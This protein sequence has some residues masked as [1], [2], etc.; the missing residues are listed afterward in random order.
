[1]KFEKLKLI[2]ILG[3]TFAGKSSFGAQS[4]TIASYNLENF[5][6]TDHDEGKNDWEFLPRAYPGR[7]E[8]CKASGEDL[9][10]CL[11]F[12]WTLPK[13]QLKVSQ[14]T[15][16]LQIAQSA[17]VSQSTNQEGDFGKTPDIVMVVEVENSKALAALSQ[18]AGYGAKNF[19][20]TNSPDIRGINVGIIFRT[21][22]HL[23]FKQ[24]KEYVVKNS[25]KPTRNILEAEFEVFGGQKLF[26]FVNHWPSQASKDS[27]PRIAAAQILAN[28]IKEIQ[29][30]NPDALVICGGDF[31]SLD[32]EK[33]H[34][35]TALLSKNEDSAPLLRDVFSVFKND[36]TIKQS[37]KNTLPKGSHYYAPDKSWGMF[38]RFFVSRNL[39]ENKNTAIDVGSFRIVNDSALTKADFS[40]S[41]SDGA[42]IPKRYNFNAT[43]AMNAGFSDHLPI[44]VKLT[45]N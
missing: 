2:L 26:A 20:I 36:A 6:D 37:V 19:A 3:L 8:G 41:G 17:L 24:S 30:Q 4:L 34:P 43:D 22:A 13:F 39:L 21:S 32:T 14:I 31:N 12:D 33:P 10:R 25:S 35:F 15:Q 42:R 16:A 23:K 5:F 18:A 27:S 44:V 7:A 40:R 28:R 1:M 38:D 11:A 9:K 29:E 45:N